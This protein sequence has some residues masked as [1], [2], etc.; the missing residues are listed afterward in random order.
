LSEDKV[1]LKIEVSREEYRRLAR[2]A[3]EAG[4]KLV[5]DYV[6]S[7]V[8]DALAG[9][10]GDCSGGAVD[11]KRLADAIAR[12]LERR[13]A[14]LINPFTAKIDEVSRRV[15]ELIEA[16]EAVEEARRE[17]PR[18]QQPRQPARR[19]YERPAPSRGMARLREEGVV[20]ESDLRGRLRQPEAFLRK[21]ESQGAIVLEVAGEK[22]AVDPEFWERLVDF[23]SKLSI[24]D[25]RE[26]ETLVDA[27]LGPRA[28]RLFSL[29]VRSGLAYYDEASASWIVRAP[30]RGPTSS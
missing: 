17:A 9:R 19:G 6:R 7:L 16:L 26:V 29:L 30:Y 13:I 10:L 21:L 20:F 1:T 15:A 22:V 12:R 11:E 23:V 4:Y 27:E 2:L 18:P 25:E 28:A 14:D 5:S 3:E 8:A 24:R